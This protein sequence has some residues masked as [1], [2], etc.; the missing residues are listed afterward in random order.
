MGNNI[1][2]FPLAWPS[3][4]RRTKTPEESKFDTPATKAHAL[5]T[6]EIG[7]MG[8]ERLI[9]STNV[10]L[11]QDG[12]M[13]MDREPVDA[14]VAV[15]FTMGGKPMVFACDK[16]DIVR[17]NILAIAKTIE[18]LRGIQR[19]GASDMMERAFSGFKA[20]SSE[21]ATKFE[22]WTVMEL[23]KNSSLEQIEARFRELAKIYHPDRPTGSH[24]AMAQL[25]QA[26]TEARKKHE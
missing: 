4:W 7:R 10:P 14:G 18:A 24:S 26:I 19:W 13:R 3:G 1:E 12:V 22:W 6:G 20:L 5:L 2:A 16:Y 17:D 9:I 15:Y 8:G 21:S 11:R 23:D 25:T